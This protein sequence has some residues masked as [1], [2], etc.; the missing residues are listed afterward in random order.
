MITLNT[1]TKVG[2]SVV[3]LAAAFGA[4]RWATP[5][6]IVIQ[7]KTVEVEKKV[8]D[9]KKDVAQH[10]H[11]TTKTVVVDKPNGEKDTSTEVVEDDNNDTKTD[12]K[13]VDNK[14]SDTES[15]KT[16]SYASSKVSVMGMFGS[17]LSLP[18]FSPPVYGLSI[19]KPVWGPLTVGAWGLSSGVAGISLGLTF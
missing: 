15:T 18:P 4:G 17:Q 10:V 13:V 6:K 11:K 19:T 1:K 7:T 5:E 2:I 12:D 16:T 14:T 3:A 9:T 8:E